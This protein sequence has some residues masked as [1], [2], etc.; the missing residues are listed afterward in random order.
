MTRSAI[1]EQLRR[2]PMPG[3]RTPGEN[4]EHIVFGR[5]L[6]LRRALGER[7]AELR[8]LLHWDDTGD[9]P[10]TAAE[11]VHGLKL[12]WRVSADCLMRRSPSESVSCSRPPAKLAPMSRETEESNRRLLHARDAID[13]AYDQPLNGTGLARIVHAGVLSGLR[14]RGGP[15]HDLHLQMGCR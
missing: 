1:A 15:V 4:A 5:A 6:H 2:R 8:P 13:R 7:M 9:P 10:H 3:V 12:T 14:R 11:I